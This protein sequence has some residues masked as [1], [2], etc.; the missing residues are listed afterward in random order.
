MASADHVIF[1][2]LEKLG[3]IK[4]PFIT[5]QELRGEFKDLFTVKAVFPNI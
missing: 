5:D 3:V 4:W 1:K 2:H